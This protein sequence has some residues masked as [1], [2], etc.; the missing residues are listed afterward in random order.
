MDVYS[1]ERLDILSAAAERPGP[2]DLHLHSYLVR[3]TPGGRVLKQKA[4]LKLVVER[5]LDAALN[6]DGGWRGSL[7]TGC[8]SECL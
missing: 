7:V 3:P 6:H 2:S 8:Y 5:N 4:G 1:A